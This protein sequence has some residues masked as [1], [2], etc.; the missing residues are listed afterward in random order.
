M[1]KENKR[2]I[3]ATRKILF[4]VTVIAIALIAV[5]CAGSVFAAA[6]ETYVVDIYDGSQVITLETKKADAEDVIAE[7]NIQLSPD[8]KLLLDD[9]RPGHNSRIVICRESNV[10]FI[11]NGESYNTIFAGTVAE[12]IDQQGVILSDN[13]FSSVNVD[14]IVTN[15]LEVK[16]I[17]LKT[18]TINVDGEKRSV[19]TTAETVGELLKEQN[20]VLDADD[21]TSPAVGTVL[22]NGMVVDVLR[23]EYETREA[24]EVIK[25]STE[26]VNSASY[27]KGE[28][29]VTQ[30]G[31]DGAKT[32]V[33]KDKIVNGVLDSSSVISETV[34]KEPKKQIVQVGTFVATSSLGNNKIE[35]NGRPISEFELPDHYSLDE[36]GVPT[37]YKYTITGRGAAYCE[38]GGLTATGKN[39]KP[40]YIA[41]DPK[42][43]PYGTEM[44]IVSTDGVVYGYAI[45]S[46]TGGFV[47]NGYFTCD[48]YMNTESQCILWGDRE[49]IIYVL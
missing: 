28:Q 39:V 12:L 2:Q 19:S 26:T 15:N 31:V 38:P 8:D 3:R 13:V 16:I 11:Y 6:G 49:V 46:D 48:L 23:V 18:I 44:W 25:Y 32:V 7:A 17:E 30:K 37:E 45:A 22:S 14:A 21:E 20:I 36:N 41:V 42:Q 29:K 1:I 33:Y 10:T 5:V 47:K 4:R 24:Q 35:K 27:K 40:G 9:F 34:T 43:I